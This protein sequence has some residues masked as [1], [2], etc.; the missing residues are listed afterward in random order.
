M[1]DVTS[2]PTLAS[3]YPA[4]SQ[5]PSS[6][7]T[8]LGQDAFLNLL[9]TQLQYQD[10]S[11]PVQNEAFVAQLA[12]FSSLEQ[13]T[14]LNDTLQGVYVAL[15]AMNNASMAGLLGTDVIARGDTFHYSG[16]GAVDLSYFAPTDAA[17]ATLTVTD[18]DGTVVWTGD[19][20]ELAQGDG[21]VSWPGVDVNGQPVPGGDYTFTITGY[22]AAGTSIDIEERISGTIDQ[23]DYSTGTPMPS[24]DGT[25]VAIGDLLTLTQGD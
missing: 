22:D 9:T 8:E 6:G 10:P 14:S 3:L 12:Q 21:T 13:L 24:I 19:V 1:A 23:M 5:T 15:A 16:D 25:P 11:N 4:P 17:S 2:I 7:S 18:D 20:G